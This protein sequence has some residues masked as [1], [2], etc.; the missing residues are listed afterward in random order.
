MYK[1]NPE[2]EKKEIIRRY[3]NVLKVWYTRKTGKDKLLVR[4]AFDVA[5][6]AHKDMRRRTGEPYIYHPLDVAR[7][8]A[9]DIGLGTTSIVCALLHDVVEDTDYTI[10]DIEGLFGEK[11]AKIIDGLTKIE[12]IFDYSTSSLQAEN[13]KKML[14]T[15]SDDVR[16]ILIKLAD[17]LHN[18]RTLDAMPLEKQMKI[19]SET[20]FLYAP[21]AHRL[22]L[23]VI[24]SELEDLVLKYTEPDI[25]QT[26]L[27]K[28]KK[29]RK[30]RNIFI[31]KFVF[32]IK[33]TLLQ[34]GI[35]ARIETKEHSIFSIWQ[36]MKS[37][38][39]PFEEIY[40]LFAVR[41]IIDTAPE[42]ERSDCW[43]VYSLITDLY[44]PKLDKLRDWI[45]FPKANGY[46]SLHSTFMSDTGRWVEVQ[47]RTIRMNEIAEKGYAAHW[48][49][50][51]SDEDESGLDEWLKKVRE[52]LQ[53]NDSD[54]IDFISDF[55]L[56]LFSDEIFVFTP[57][58]ELK[59]LPVGSTV[60]DFA[61]NI[62]TQIGDQCIGGKINHELV[63]VKYVLKS[64][65]QVEIITTK[66]QIP[67][68][69]RLNF[70]ITARAKSR[71]K[72]L[73]KEERKK[74]KSQG[75]KKLKEYFKDLNIE[76]SRS[77]L[78]KLQEFIEYSSSIDLYYFVAADKIGLKEI[79]SSF[80]I[81]DRTLFGYKL[82]FSRVKK[83]KTIN[84]TINEKVRNKPESLILDTD[85]NNIKYIIADC[86]NPIPGDDVIGY[87][88]D[89]DAI[90]VHRTNC[91]QASKLMS[92]YGDKIVK[93]KWEREKR[94]SFLAGI[95]ITAVDN[96]GLI[97]NIS[98]IISQEFNVNIRSFHL[99]TSE[100]VTHAIIL[101][102][103]H[104]TENLKTIIKK[105]RKIKEIKKIS[106]IDRLS[107]TSL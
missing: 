37:K 12:D 6:E 41:I 92:R 3:R 82:P 48:K 65:D 10:K 39:I 68:E 77:N 42:N 49:Y 79:K 47:I 25:Y 8:A 16:A 51:N 31:D 104:D 95:K 2:I 36:K 27:K 100:G 7:I 75:I 78:R 60:L 89:K 5:V 1:V 105:L 102:Y 20:R 23:Y 50:K 81:E 57:K 84:E 22:G 71:I 72:D 90:F 53:S 99:E 17:R 33:E 73:I 80:Q 4:K 107:E 52:L 62:H 21:L 11:V 24:K 40:D 26:I 18:M 106:R 70:V 76:Y 46:E 19:C 98:T 66:K 30:D 13:F 63:P 88:D 15:L 94:I 97:N 103:V 59:N 35:N 32:P 74:Y 28:F 86:C 87:F 93:A 29:T 14:L 44:R 85:I 61:Y 96:V 38:E 9:E 91:P 69:D 67:N 43:K 56:N 34:N 101:I 55:K 58:G 54:A 45:S 64:G 83:S